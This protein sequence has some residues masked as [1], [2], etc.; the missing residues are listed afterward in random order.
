VRAV[1]VRRCPAAAWSS[2]R[3]AA[4]RPLPVTLN[5]A[6]EHNVRNALAAIAVAQELELPDEP[7][8]QAL[9]QFA[10]VGRRFT[11]MANC[12]PPAVAT[13]R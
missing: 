1:H 7:V 12:L 2:R 3:S 13:S 11:R 8:A 4:A 5:L 9:A 6:G 10:G